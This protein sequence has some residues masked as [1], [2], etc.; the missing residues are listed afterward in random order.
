MRLLSQPDYLLKD[1]GLQR[2]VIT[3]EGMKRFWMS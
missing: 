3:R 2:D 1:I